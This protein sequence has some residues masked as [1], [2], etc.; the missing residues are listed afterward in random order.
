MR[1]KQMAPEPESKRRY[2]EPNLNARAKLIKAHISQAHASSAY[3]EK[4][5]AAKFEDTDFILNYHT[6]Y[7]R[8]F[9]V[10]RHED[11]QPAKRIMQP[12]KQS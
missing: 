8:A 12:H 9:E 2:K 1:I 6:F 7:Q 5:R 4:L 11:E 3:V 10:V